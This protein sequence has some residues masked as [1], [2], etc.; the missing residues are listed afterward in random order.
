MVSYCVATQEVVEELRAT[1]LDATDD[2]WRVF[3]T[4]ERAQMEREI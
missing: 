4:A 1:I 2:M 3:W